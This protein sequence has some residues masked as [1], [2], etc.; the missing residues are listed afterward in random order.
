MPFWNRKKNWEDEYDEFYTQDRRTGEPGTRKRS[1]GL[2]LFAHTLTLIFV[3]GI[4]LGAAGSIGGR[5]MLEKIVTEL[6]MPIGIVWCAL[7]FMVYF[8]LLTRQAWPAVVGF[9]CWMVLIVAGNSYFS[10]WLI[11]TLEKP[12]QSINVL[13]MDPVETIVILGGGTSSRLSGSAQLAFAG[14]RVAIGARLYHAGKVKN[15]ICTGS[16]TLSS[17]AKDLSPR[18]EAA[19]I[20]AGIDVPRECITQMKGK[21]TFEEMANLKA[22]LDATPDHGKVGIVTSAWHLPRALRLAKTHDLELT[23]IPCNFLS[24]PYGPKPNLFVPGSYPIQVTTFAVKEYL[25][26]LVNR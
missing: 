20:L 2:R 23:P 22:W 10:N 17:S 24:E 3:G 12:Y 11:S 5:A 25:A 13:D 14:D 7:I 26:G 15:L 1:T 9:S 4:F 16:N 21:N 18:E 19:E 6:A 8:C